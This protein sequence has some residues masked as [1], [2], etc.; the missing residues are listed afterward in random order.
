MQ[1]TFAYWLR[2][3]Q[4]YKKKLVEYTN[5]KLIN[6]CIEISVLK[7]CYIVIPQTISL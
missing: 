7:C 1:M 6:L 5:E 2:L 3:L 4:N